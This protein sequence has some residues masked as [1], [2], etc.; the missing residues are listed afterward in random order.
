MHE[1][2]R[3]NVST[4]TP[5]AFGGGDAQAAREVAHAANRVSL[6][7]S[8]PGLTKIRAIEYNRSAISTTALLPAAQALAAG[9][10]ISP[11]INNPVAQPRL[12]GAQRMRNRPKA[13]FPP[14][15]P[16]RVN[17]W[18]R[19]GRRQ[20]SRPSLVIVYPMERA[21]VVSNINGDR[22]RTKAQREI[23]DRSSS[24]GVERW[25]RL[26]IATSCERYSHHDEKR[27]PQHRKALSFWSLASNV[28]DPAKVARSYVD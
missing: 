8:T 10:V 9:A 2:P 26:A 19:A 5:T 23:R 21:L 1:A 6:R 3:G 18:R 22:W 17:R 14:G 25:G 11:V 15:F 4:N 27:F 20:R 12:W 13:A 7:I 16:Q 24:V 28:A